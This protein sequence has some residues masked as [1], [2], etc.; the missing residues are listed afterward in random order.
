MA[1]GSFAGTTVRAT[2]SPP[3]TAPTSN[4]PPGKLEERVRAAAERDPEAAGL[5]VSQVRR[6]IESVVRYVLGRAHGDAED[7]TKFSLGVVRCSNAPVPAAHEVQ[8]LC[9][10]DLLPR[11]GKTESCTTGRI[12]MQRIR[13]VVCGSDGPNVYRLPICGLPTTCASARLGS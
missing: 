9:S 12:G 4:A 10:S 13:I 6:A 8:C 5:L 7:V 11:L 2:I 1:S 3:T